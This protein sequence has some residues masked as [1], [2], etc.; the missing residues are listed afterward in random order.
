M[1]HFACGMTRRSRVIRSLIVD[2]PGTTMAAVLAACGDTHHMPVGATEGSEVA[3]LGPSRLSTDRCLLH[4]HDSGFCGSPPPGAGNGSTPAPTGRPDVRPDVCA[5]QLRD[6]AVRIQP[7]AA[8]PA[9]ATRSQSGQ[10]SERLVS[11]ASRARQLPNFR[12]ACHSRPALARAADAARSSPWS[13]SAQPESFRQRSESPPGGRRDPVHQRPIEVP[14]SVQEPQQRT[15][16][17]GR[18]LRR[19]GRLR[20]ACRDHERNDRRSIQP[21]QLDP[22]RVGQAP[23]R[24]A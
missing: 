5:P 24:T 23:R 12:S 10:L 8:D 18:A 2:G 15:Q 16:R 9:S 7:V 21:I 14:L 6:L 17:H 13:W 4:D 22:R 19:G 3:D 1:S 11:I 20:R